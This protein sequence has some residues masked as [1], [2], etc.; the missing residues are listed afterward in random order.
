MS[1]NLVRKGKVFSYELSVKMTRGRARGKNSPKRSVNGSL[2]NLSHFLIQSEETP[3]PIIIHSYTF[4]CTSC[5]LH[6]FTSSFD[7]F[8]GL[9]ISFVIGQSNTEKPAFRQC[10]LLQGTGLN[11]AKKFVKISSHELI[12]TNF[13]T[14]FSLVP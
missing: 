14:V 12:L 5:Q 6:L 7:W 3:K 13:L 4:S 10:C 11:T 2:K 8:T 9:P 1:G